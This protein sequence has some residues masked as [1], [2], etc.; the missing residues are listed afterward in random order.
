MLHN[1]KVSLSRIL[2]VKIHDNW[3]AHL[4]FK[5]VHCGNWYAIPLQLSSNLKYIEQAFIWAHKWAITIIFLWV[6]SIYFFLIN[7]DTLLFPQ[8]Q[9]IIWL[10]WLFWNPKSL[11]NS[12][13]WSVL[14]FFG[15]FEGITGQKILEIQ[16]CGRYNLEPHL[17]P[18]FHTLIFGHED[19]AQLSM[20][21]K[22]VFYSFLI[23]RLDL[24]LSAATKCLI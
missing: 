15:C 6:I 5:G 21:K 23:L 22:A 1:E 8:V 20:P 3:T 9:S 4:W 13:F 14:A 16:V 2:L 11:K 17:F 10:I 24:I 7:M 12:L 18:S 19:M